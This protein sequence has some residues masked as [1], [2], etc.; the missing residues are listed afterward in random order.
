MAV[1]CPFGPL[2]LLIES[3]RENNRSLP[4]ALIYSA[5]VW[6]MAYPDEPVA[7]SSRGPPSLST[8]TNHANNS[9][10]S[11]KSASLSGSDSESPLKPSSSIRREPFEIDDDEEEE[12]SGLK[13]GLGDF[14]FYSVLIGRAAL[15]DWIT[16]ITCTVAVLNGLTATIF[17]L[18]VY[19]KPLPALPI[20]IILG[21]LFYFLAAMILVPF[22]ESLISIRGASGSQVASFVF[23]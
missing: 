5:A 8:P 20:S 19:S 23:I 7:S 3:F 14:V 16:T 4:S 9:G 12:R 22:L 1:L 13:L 21:I 11:H 15:Y 6:F 10:E 18:I 2:K 17:L